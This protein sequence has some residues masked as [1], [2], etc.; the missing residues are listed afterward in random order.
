MASSQVDFSNVKQLSY[1]EYEVHK[2]WFPDMEQ[3][4]L[5]LARISPDA[6]I[7]SILIEPTSTEMLYSEFILTVVEDTFMKDDAVEN[8]YI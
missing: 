7:T 4:S 5:F 1:H 3:V 6:C 8:E 2:L